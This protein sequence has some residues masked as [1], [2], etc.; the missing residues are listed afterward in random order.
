VPTRKRKQPLRGIGAHVGACPI[1][2]NPLWAV[3]FQFDVTV[4]GRT[5]KLLN[6]I[7]EFTCECLAIEVDRSIDRPR[8]QDPRPARLPARWGARV[9]AVR[10]RT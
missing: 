1:P 10:P 8:C 7:H 2:P 5:L 6:V 3:D 9:R 4:D